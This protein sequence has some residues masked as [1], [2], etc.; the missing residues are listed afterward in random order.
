MG[1]I[2]K[3][4][5]YDNLKEYFIDIGFVYAVHRQKLVVKL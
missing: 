3:Y 2:Q 5:F 4:K 1:G